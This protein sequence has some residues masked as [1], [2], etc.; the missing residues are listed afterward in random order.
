[1]MKLQSFSPRVRRILSGAVAR[2]MDEGVSGRL[3][4]SFRETERSGLMLAATLSPETTFS[5][6]AGD[7]TWDAY[8]NPDYLPLI[9]LVND[10]VIFRCIL[11]GLVV[12]VWRSRELVKAAAI[13]EKARANL[14]RHFSPKVFDEFSAR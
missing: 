9:K 13:S 8:S 6:P 5:L 2:A 7:A 1:M 3:S 12:A 4:D 14:A 11:A 10:F